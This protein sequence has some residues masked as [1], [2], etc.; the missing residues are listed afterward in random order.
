[1]RESENRGPVLLGSQDSGSTKIIT[2]FQLDL[3]RNDPQTFLI[4][5]HVR[6]VLLSSKYENHKLY[7]VMQLNSSSLF[8][9]IA[10]ALFLS[11]FLHISP[12]YPARVLVLLLSLSFS[13]SILGLCVLSSGD[14]A[15]L[16]LISASSLSW[17]I[18]ATVAQREITF[19]WAYFTPNRQ[20]DRS[21][22]WI[23][24]SDTKW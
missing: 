24:C 2:T 6:T 13:S 22:C 18:V 23:Y 17:F 5:N 3:N 11:N 14:A 1:M 4:I 20:D 12:P 15:A 8:S 9:V 21:S 19:Q 7:L 16:I 10:V